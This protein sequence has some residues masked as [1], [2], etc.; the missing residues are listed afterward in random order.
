[1]NVTLSESLEKIQFNHFQFSCIIAKFKH[2]FHHVI[3]KQY[4][5]SDF[6]HFSTIFI[7]FLFFHLSSIIHYAFVLNQLIS[8]IIQLIS[9]IIQLISSIIQLI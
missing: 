5:A 3:I 1:M 8:F 6:I 4:S 7:H 9:S 2:I